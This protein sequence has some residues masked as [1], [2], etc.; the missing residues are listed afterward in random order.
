MSNLNLLPALSVRFFKYDHNEDEEVDIVE[1]E[2]EEFVAGLK[3][4]IPVEY[5][6]HTVRENGVS[7]ICMTLLTFGR[8]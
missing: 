4:D 5:E 6:R 2:E 8:G 1:I 3:L 7:Q